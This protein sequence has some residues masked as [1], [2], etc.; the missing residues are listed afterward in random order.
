MLDRFVFLATCLCVK[1]ALGPSSFTK[2][3][4]PSKEISREEITDSYSLIRHFKQVAL[5]TT[6]LIEVIA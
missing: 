5:F 3:A 4:K 2:S 1:A 6:A